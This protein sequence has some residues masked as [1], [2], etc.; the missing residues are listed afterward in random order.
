VAR[1]LRDERRRCDRHRDF[2]DAHRIVGRV[3]LGDV[4]VRR[5]AQSRAAG[6]QFG[7]KRGVDEIDRQ[8]AEIEGGI[9]GCRQRSG[10]LAGVP[11]GLRCGWRKA[12]AGHL[13]RARCCLAGGP[14]DREAVQFGHRGKTPLTLRSGASQATG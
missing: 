12:M 6:V 7:A 2:R 9:A 4:P 5:A 3:I 1:R 10:F 14:S 13:E 11:A 8:R